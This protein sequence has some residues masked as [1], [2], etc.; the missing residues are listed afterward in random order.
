MLCDFSASSCLTKQV[1]FEM[2]KL[3]ADDAEIS[4]VLVLQGKEGV[5]LELSST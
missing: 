1:K 2:V 4:C 5:L 3:S